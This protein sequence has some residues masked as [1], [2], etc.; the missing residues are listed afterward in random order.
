VGHLS[1]GGLGTIAELKRRYPDLKIVGWHDGYFDDSQPVIKQIN[2]SGANL[3][4]VAMGSPKQE[5]WILHHRQ[6][7]NANICMGVGGSLDIA[8][9]SIRRAPGVFR[10]IGAEFLFRLI[11]EPRKR[12]RIQK[13]LFPYFANVLGKKAA[14]LTLSDEGREE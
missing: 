3:L 12:W 13:V 1:A 7:I 10:M 9:G 4:F 11:R 8:S 5:Q 14:D 2:S 6:A